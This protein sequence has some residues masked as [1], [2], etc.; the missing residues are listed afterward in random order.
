MSTQYIKNTAQPVVAG[1]F[2][3]I[4][5]AFSMLGVLGIG[6]AAAVITPFQNAIPFGMGLFFTAIAVPLA[7]I[8]IV[9]IV[10]GVFALQ[11]RMGGGALAG[12]ITTA[13]ISP[14]LL[15]IASIVLIIL[16]RDEFGQ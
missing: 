3:I 1:V 13:L 8:G 7:A 15:G 6:V 11:R 16:S 10:G 2:N 5:G 9:S 4:M 12:S 14:H